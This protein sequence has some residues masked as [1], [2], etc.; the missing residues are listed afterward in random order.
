MHDLKELCLQWLEAEKLIKLQKGSNMVH[1]YQ[2]A[3]NSL[4]AFPSVVKNPR[5]LQILHG[6]GPK[7]CQ[8]LD[9][10][11]KLYC[12]ANGLNY[13]EFNDKEVDGDDDDTHANDNADSDNDNGSNGLKRKRNN[14]NAKKQTKQ[15]RKQY[16]PKKN[17]GGYAILI[18]LLSNDRDRTGLRKGEICQLAEKFSL[19]TFIEQ[20]KSNSDN[21][22]NNNYTAWSS[23]NT[24]LK[25]EYIEIS[26]NPPRFTLT[27]AGEKI[28]KVCKQ[29]EDENPL[30]SKEQN[31][32]ADFVVPTRKNNVKRTLSRRNPL[33][34]SSPATSANNSIIEANSSI[35]IED[36]SERLRT[37]SP[38]PKR[39]N[40]ATNNS[41]LTSNFLNE[42]KSSIDGINYE[43][44]APSEYS[45]RFVLDKREV[46]SKADRDAF[47]V[48]LE[49]KNVDVVSKNLPVGDGAWIA[50]HNK[51]G[52]L[53]I[54]D[55]IFER[56]CMNDLLSSIHDD[57][58]REQESR[59]QKSGLK[60]IM[61]L[62]E[63]E[64][65]GDF[66][67]HRDKIMTS[68]MMME[69]YLKATL[70]RTNNI[71]ETVKFIVEF[72]NVVSRYYTKRYLHVLN[73]K[74]LHDAQAYFETIERVR[75]QL[76][77]KNGA[78]LHLGAL[79]ADVVY[80]FEIFEHLLQKKS[81]MKVKDLF[82]QCLRCIKGV[83]LDKAVSIQQ[84][85]KFPK[86]LSLAYK[87]YQ[88]DKGDMLM[89]RT[90]DKIGSRK[91]NKKLSQA[92]ADFWLSNCY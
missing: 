10:K 75:P 2:K 3:I 87:T 66:L 70:A 84:E 36:I 39:K 44:W 25:N 35:L 69:T 71:Q 89:E 31:E 64:I 41:N 5:D 78:K 37:D 4:V 38:E 9:A 81:S 77:N 30:H 82:V 50:V 54:L 17:S 24:L 28:A 73:P 57:R 58:F 92:I 76:Q 56:K 12:E 88:Y 80:D 29:M 79:K 63:G 42:S 14:T 62:V 61:Y 86:N 33:V 22:G 74:H 7:I 51:S 16:I 6:F 11:L 21:N 40:D 19:T 23:R 8:I 83:S 60:H 32:N 72:N 65:K 45:V 85:F 34:S 67:L 68:M 49:N 52:K 48:I 20:S 26:G 46:W 1:T 59:L 90:K 91:I 47:S 55:Y 27:D 13:S 53:A 43:T 15:R 18:A